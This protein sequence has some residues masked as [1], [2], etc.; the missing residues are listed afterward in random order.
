MVYGVS[1]DTLSNA[2]QSPVLKRKGHVFY[3]ILHRPFVN[4]KVV[5]VIER[6]RMLF[7]LRGSFWVKTEQLH[8][9]ISFCLHSI[10]NLL[11]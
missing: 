7:I 4:L 9:R 3:F 5:I 11:A 8:S 1:L 10:T 2:S 6:T